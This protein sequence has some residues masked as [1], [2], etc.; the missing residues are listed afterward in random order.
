MGGAR[1]AIETGYI[2][3]EI[4]EAAYAALQAIESGEQTVI[5]VD[6]FAAKVETG[7]LDLLRVDEAA[8]AEQVARLAAVRA[9]RDQGVVAGILERVRATAGCPG[10]P[11]MP[12]FVEAVRAYATLGEYPTRCATCSGNTGHEKAA[13]QQHVLCLRRRESGGRPYQVL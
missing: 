4:Q 11:L 9:S 1:K 8:Q 7:V 10:A 5:G 3:N 12:L 13:D 6:K 2:Q